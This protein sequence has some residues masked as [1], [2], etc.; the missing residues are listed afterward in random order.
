MFADEVISQAVTRHFEEPVESG[1]CFGIPRHHLKR[2]GRVVE[3]ALFCLPDVVLCCGR[4]VNGWLLWVAAP[5]YDF[6][7][8]FFSLCLKIWQ[9]AAYERGL[10]FGLFFFWTIKCKTT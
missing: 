10:N 2:S 1:I 3:R 8:G 5:A 7:Q 6:S 4:G 9:R